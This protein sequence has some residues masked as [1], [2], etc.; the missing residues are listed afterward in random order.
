[1][2]SKRL[3]TRDTLD[4][5]K[6]NMAVNCCCVHWQGA[7]RNWNLGSSSRADKWMIPMQHTVQRRVTINFTKAG[8]SHQNCPL[9]WGKQEQSDTSIRGPTRVSPANSISIGSYIFAQV[10][11]HAYIHTNRITCDICSNKPHL[12]SAWWQCGLKITVK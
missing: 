7:L 4:W 9:L 1:M 12:F 5:K 10:S 6:V 8:T 3:T 2:V 11:T